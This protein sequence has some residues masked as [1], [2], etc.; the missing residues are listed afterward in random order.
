MTKHTHQ[1][2]DVVTSEIPTGLLL[3]STK[4]FKA[5]IC[6]CGESKYIERTNGLF[7]KGEWEASNEQKEEQ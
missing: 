6:N 5:Q 4:E 7:R 3:L 1:W 2:Q